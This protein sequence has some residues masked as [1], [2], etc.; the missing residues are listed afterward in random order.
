MNRFPPVSA[1]V[2][3]MALV[4]LFALA[5]AFAAKLS[6]QQYNDLM[7]RA[8]AAFESRD[9]ARAAEGYTAV[10][11]KMPD[12]QAAEKRLALLGLARSTVAASDW[13]GALQVIENHAALLED[14]NHDA[15]VDEL[16]HHAMGAAAALGRGKQQILYAT[17]IVERFRARGNKTNR[18]VL[19]AEINLGYAMLTNGLAQ[20]GRNT[21]NTTLQ[22]MRNA[23]QHDSYV[24][25]LNTVAVTLNNAGFLDDAAF[26]FDL[27]VSEL[28]RLPADE[29]FGVTLF[30][31]AILRADQNKLEEAAALHTK[32]IE[33]LRQTLGEEAQQTITAV[34]GLGNTYVRFGRAASGV[35]FLKEAHEQSRKV[36]GADNNETW[37]SGNNYANA[38][39]YLERFEEA[40]V[41]DQQAYDWRMANL[42][43]EN[44]ETEISARNLALDLIGLRKPK[45]AMPLFERIYVSSRKRLGEKHP[46]TLEALGGVQ[47]ALSLGAK[48]KLKLP[49]QAKVDVASLDRATANTLGGQLDSAG[50]PKEAL[51]YYQ[52]A[53]TASEKEDGWNHPTTLLMLRNV[54]RLQRS[55]NPTESI[56][57][58]TDLNQRTLGW[59]RREIGASGDV[60]MANQIR[61]LSNGMIFDIARFAMEDPRATPLLAQIMLDWK[62]V[63]SLE[64]SITQGLR[65]NPPT[66]E[67]AAQLKR[68]DALRA[69]LQA[70]GGNAKQTR[71]DLELAESELAKASAGLRNLELQN[72]TTVSD[73]AKQ[74]S[75]SDLVIDYLVIRNSEA[76]S[77]QDVP[78][79]V[80]L[81]TTSKGP[82]RVFDLG[83]LADVTAHFPRDDNGFD[84]P[85]RKALFHKLIAPLLRDIADAKQ[86]FIVP[87][88]ALFLVP[89]DG[90]LED[91]GRALMQFHDFS[92]LRNA[93][94]LLRKTTQQPPRLLLVGN[95]DFGQGNAADVLPA[96]PGSGVE[97]EK[98][99]SMAATNQV[100]VASLSGAGATEASVRQTSQGKTIVHLATHGFFLPDDG[101]SVDALWRAGIALANAAPLDTRTPDPDNGLALAGEIIDWPLQGVE[102]VVLSA[103]ATA[104]GDLSAVD[105][106][107]GL[108]S[109]LAVAGATRSLLTLWPI[110]DAGTAAFMTRFYE[111]LWKE[112]LGYEAA[113]RAVKREA[114]EGKIPG[115][116]DE[117]LWQAFV[118]IRN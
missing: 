66:S 23:G 76:G 89:F 84:R 79:V 70:A 63:G 115:A 6:A 17:R 18:S 35:Q 77:A 103:C 16:L 60:E 101:D 109:A 5:P 37:I 22:T 49:K 8:D 118:L 58:Y 21:L 42:G 9:Y 86:L 11:T 113:F 34:A 114:M 112:K 28:E 56:A 12:A 26:Y 31:F 67:V 13:A 92:I 20:E 62:T 72:K 59:S 38:L 108:P 15:A 68:I 51:P 29:R 48:T 104:Q 39:R 33:V 88:D 99:A 69:D 71:I 96:L 111:K 46:E 32:A 2:T 95:P 50:K 25:S 14:A 7:A 19:Q 105:G 74:L 80:A 36:Y 94:A 81:L 90:L 91:K 107:R 44:R 117:R 73:V 65:A 30:N 52:Q 64:Q 87:D 85:S 75:A 83:P 102:L 106:L 53:V 45:E 1:L 40:R 110:D 10:L 3:T 4:F 27:L 97:V 57:L 98:I 24:A 43:P 93:R 61:T 100:E 55:L 82:Q 78:T 54:A 116:E 47:L 41:I